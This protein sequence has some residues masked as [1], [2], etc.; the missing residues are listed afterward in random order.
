MGPDGLAREG[1]L[2][3]LMAWGRIVTYWYSGVKI[4]DFGVGCQKWWDL[5]VGPDGLA[6]EGNLDILMAW[7]QDSDILVF[8][9]ENG[10]F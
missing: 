3:I 5:P 8:W 6:R 10:R 2:D 4:M 7:G 9:Y 1:N